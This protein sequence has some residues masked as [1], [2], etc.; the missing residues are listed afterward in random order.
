MIDTYI[1]RDVVYYAKETKNLQPQMRRYIISPFSLSYW[2][3]HLINA[4]LPHHFSY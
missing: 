2:M 4:H 3:G 1:Q